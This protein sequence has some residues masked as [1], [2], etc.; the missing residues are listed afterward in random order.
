MTKLL[1]VFNL[2]NF[3]A[4]DE[5]VMTGMYINPNVDI[6][7]GQFDQDINVLNVGNFNSDFFKH[8]KVNNIFL[9][10]NTN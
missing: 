3:P 2:D 4:S 1:K 6:K 7:N 8:E 5:S 10:A 9:D